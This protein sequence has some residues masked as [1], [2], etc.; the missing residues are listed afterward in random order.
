MRA[1]R[2]V[3]AERAQ[4]SQLDAEVLVH[5]AAAHGV[6]DVEKEVAPAV[7]R[8]ALDALVGRVQRARADAAA[9]R[10]QLGV[11]EPAALRRIGLHYIV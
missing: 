1:V 8:R 9:Q 6:G 7:P 11:E 3:H 5:L 10:A 4:V 2:L